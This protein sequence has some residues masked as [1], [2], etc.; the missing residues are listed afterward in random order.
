MTPKADLTNIL[1]GI[2]VKRSSGASQYTEID[3]LKGTKEYSC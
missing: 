2:L 3:I 1:K